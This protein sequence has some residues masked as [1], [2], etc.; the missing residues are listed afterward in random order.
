MS[1][2]RFSSLLICFFITLHLLAC[3]ES[4]TD[5]DPSP[6]PEPALEILDP[7]SA[8][9]ASG[10]TAKF[11]FS[12]NRQWN[13]GIE[14]QQ[15]DEGA[16]YEVIPVSGEAGERIAVTVRV[17]SHESYT[18]R[19]F[20]LVLRADAL[21]KRVE[22][23]Q[24][25]KN[26]ILLGDSRREVGPENST[27]TVDVQSNINYAVSFKACENW[28]SE[29][30]E[31]RVA[32]GLETGTHTFRIAQNPS[33]QKRTGIIVFTDNDSDL[34]DELEIVQAARENPEPVPEP[35]ALKAFYESAGGSGWTRN[36]NWCSEKPL[37]EWYGVETDADGRVV[38][39][40]L[41]GNNLTGMLSDKLSSLTQLQ[42]LDLS[43]NKLNGHLRTE[44]G[45]DHF[46]L[47]SLRYLKTLNL[48]HNRFEGA[49][50][51]D[52]YKL[53]QLQT[54]DLSANRMSGHAIPY[55]WWTRMFIG[56]RMVELILNDNHFYGEIP[57]TIQNH[58]EWDRMALQMI[59]Q[60]K[61]EG[62]AMRVGLDYDKEIHLPD[63]TYTDLRDA[64]RRSIRG[65][66]SSNKMTMLLAWDPTQ[67]ESNTFMETTVRR[68]HTLYGAQ[69][70]AVVAI[71]PEGERYR[72]AA[73]QYLHSHKV[74]WPVASDYADFRGRRIILPS[75]PYPSYMLFDQ[76]GT[77]MQ[78]RY[79]GQEKDMYFPGEPNT[80]QLLSFLHADEMSRTLHDVFGNS[81]YEST[82]FSRDKTCET[83]QTATRG[84]GIDLVLIGD[85][86]TDIDIETNFYRQ[87]MEYAMESFF[88]IEPMKSYREYF[89]V[90]MVYAVSPKA[91]L[92]ENERNS[93]L[94]TATSTNPDKGYIDPYFKIIR[95]EY[96]SCCP[97]PATWYRYPSIIVNNSG[98]AVTFSED[99][100]TYAFV[101]YSPGARTD[102]HTLL[103]HEGIGHGFGYLADEYWNFTN[104]EKQ[105]TDLEIRRLQREQAR[106]RSLNV[107]LSNDPAQV[108]WS[109]LIGHPN[110][111]E[112]G[113][114]EG[115]Y[116]YMKGVW[117]SE[118]KSVMNSY[119]HKSDYFSA[120][121][122]ELIVKQI[123]EL[124]GEGYTFEKFLARDR[125]DVPVE[126][127]A[128][129]WKKLRQRCP[130]Y[131][132]VPP[133][134]AE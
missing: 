42:H 47:S 51:E 129:A 83:L 26:V 95:E 13:I 32:P 37:D 82:D 58:P 72:S 14:L 76:N 3:S 119:L 107:S 89:N 4:K 15:G 92:S 69:G 70:F 118:D 67:D 131:R 120:I 24:D 127:N 53:G 22:V 90:R 86:F 45:S 28:I 48:S 5:D 52:W 36:D 20:T 73:L 109:H 96:L 78:D 12:A 98:A 25:K 104:V 19:S 77:L 62:D 11:T 44:D 17:D 55:E 18:P 33:A 9:A 99:G 63:F 134:W 10:G 94:Q 105:I 43:R 59:R 27:F 114:Y 101:G 81:E 100:P 40:R 130:P 74:N 84:K 1:D 68:F 122:R 102:M 61:M 71:T 108:P 23:V 75:N 80:V 31:S 16:W 133:V 60:T 56:G 79:N 2:S 7:L 103:H 87:L 34:S 88:V 66:Y 46:H 132:H 116:L 35:V 124:S 121:H 6:A 38:A 125:K 85:A 97:P 112:V 93:A 128:A 111:P 49:V 106:N 110:Y 123:L 50:A 115:G 54:L 21:E 117:R 91:Y 57:P 126:M 113:I 65:L 30:P 29:V 64:S 39:L 41:S 8:F